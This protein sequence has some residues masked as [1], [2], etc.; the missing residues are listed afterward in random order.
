MGEYAD[1]SIHDGEIAN[2]FG[3]QS[4]IRREKTKC[5]YCGKKGLL[6]FS[7]ART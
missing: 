1:M 5:R 3:A 7:S 2:L 4:F 6:N